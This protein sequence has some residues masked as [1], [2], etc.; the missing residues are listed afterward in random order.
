VK[1]FALRRLIRLERETHLNRVVVGDYRWR[2]SAG[3]QECRQ[4]LLSRG[5]CQIAQDIGCYSFCGVGVSELTLVKCAFTILAYCTLG[6][7]DFT[8]R[9]L[10]PETHEFISLRSA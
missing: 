7:R 2:G 9:Q 5:D 6:T 1:R 10:Q 3:S 4:L 8:A